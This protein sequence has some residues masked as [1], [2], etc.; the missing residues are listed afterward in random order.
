MELNNQIS[1]CS[2]NINHYDDVKDAQAK[3]E[4]SALETLF[5]NCTF[6][7]LQE[8]WLTEDEF[9]RKF[10]NHFPDSECVAASKME[11]NNIKRGRPYGGVSI[12][13]H[14][15]IKCNVEI[16]PTTSKD[17][18]AQKIILDNVSILL[19][20]VYIPCY[21]NRDSLDEYTV[22]LQES[23][24]ICSKYETNVLSIGGD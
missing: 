1:F 9:I 2:Y 19:I 21:D 17:I 16:I 4:P 6:L 11:F 3:D 12:C 18:C 15:K 22:I 7:I 13:Y 8:T 20:N 24:N 10:K 5:E 14:S 23:S